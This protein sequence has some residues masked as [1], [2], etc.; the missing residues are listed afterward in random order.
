[1]GA[2]GAWLTPWNSL[3]LFFYVVMAGGIVALG[4]LIWQGTLWQ[5]LRRAWDFLLNLVLTR[6][7]GVLSPSEPSPSMPRHHALRRG[8]CPG[9]GGPGGFWSCFLSYL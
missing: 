7:R 8:H 4:M 1:M 2:L 6:G 5:F 9:H 3:S